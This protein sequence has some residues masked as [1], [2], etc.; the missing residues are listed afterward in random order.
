MDVFYVRER[1]GSEQK[2]SETILY[3][4]RANRHHLVRL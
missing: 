3:N 1:G 4:Q 2:F